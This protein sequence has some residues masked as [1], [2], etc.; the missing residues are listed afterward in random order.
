MGKNTKIKYFLKNKLTNSFI[1]TLKSRFD[2]KEEKKEFSTKY[3]MKSECE[4]V[5][6]TIE[7]YNLDSNYEAAILKQVGETSEGMLYSIPNAKI[8]QMMYCIAGTCAIT[9]GNKKIY[10]LKKGDILICNLSSEN[11]REYNLKSKDSKKVMI[12]LD[13]DKLESDIL[14][15]SVDKKI[16]SNWERKVFD[17]F[18]NDIFCYGKSNSQIDI[19]ISQLENMKITNMNEYFQFKMRI[20]QLLFIILE[21]QIG[22]LED[23]MISDSEVTEK[24]KE[25][26]KQYSIEKMPHVREI[27]KIM[28]LSNYQLQRAFRNIEGIS[29]SRYIQ[30]KK[31]EYAKMLLE[32]TNTNILDIAIEIG[33][34]NPSKFSIAFKK[35]FG[36]LPNK[37]RKKSK[38]SSDAE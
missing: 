5:T 3:Y 9:K 12:F 28:G 14:D 1:G 19:L 24:I 25:I 33:Y 23:I 31:M 26:L 38:N 15:S 32:T 2:V 30:K 7:R 8:I 18:E 13:M 27:C 10:T 6:V 34:E 22:S 4:G 16:L 36:I 11:V 37:Y 35:N 29:V 17:I 20:S 21:I